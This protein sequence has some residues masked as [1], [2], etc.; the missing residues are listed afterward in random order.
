MSLNVEGFRTVVINTK[1]DHMLQPDMPQ[2]PS[3]LSHQA[4][5]IVNIHDWFTISRL[6]SRR[7]WSAVLQK[8]SRFRASSQI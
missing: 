8:L 6:K 5:I 3:H 4:T 1:W 2:A 7:L